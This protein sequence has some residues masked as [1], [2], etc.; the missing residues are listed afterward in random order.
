M[1]R[2]FN[3]KLVRFI[4]ITGGA[5]YVLWRS[6]AAIIGEPTM[7]FH[8]EIEGVDDVTV[9]RNVDINDFIA[10]W[11]DFIFVFFVLIF[12]VWLSS[13][14]LVRIIRRSPEVGF[15]KSSAIA[16]S[17]YLSGSLILDALSRV[18]EKYN[19]DGLV[20][21]AA[22]IAYVFFSAIGLVVVFP[23]ML[24]C[25]AFILFVV[26]EFLVRRIAEQPK[27][28]LAAFSAIATGVGAIL[29]AFT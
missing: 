13:I 24:F 16:T 6:A 19:Q 27:G 18:A 3:R 26:I 17:I 7:T 5:M 28:P 23:V 14:F 4:G 8:F 12:A 20:H 15:I 1:L 10:H 25:L 29:K 22:V 9:P 2:F 21:M 11:P